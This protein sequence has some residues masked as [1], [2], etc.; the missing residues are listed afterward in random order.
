MACNSQAPA[1]VPEPPVA[2]VVPVVP[3]VPAAPASLLPSGQRELSE[4]RRQV[5]GRIVTRKIG[6]VVI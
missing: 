4:Q 3:V 5:Q 6:F 1:A 2:P